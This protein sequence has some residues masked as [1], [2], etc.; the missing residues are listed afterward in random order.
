MLAELPESDKKELDA[1]YGSLTLEPSYVA[2][3]DDHVAFYY[4]TL[5][6]GT[7]DFYFRT[8]AFVPGT[9]IQP[10]ASA[11]M[12]YDMAVQGN[13]AGARVVVSPKGD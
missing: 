10:A 3:L 8:K 6:K 13:S 9:Y 1:R 2:A 7:F 4:D 12:M 5:P 11:Q